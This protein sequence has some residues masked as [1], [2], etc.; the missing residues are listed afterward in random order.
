MSV[1]CTFFK[2]RFIFDTEIKTTSETESLFLLRPPFLPEMHV[3]CEDQSAR[4]SQHFSD[5]FPPLSS[6]S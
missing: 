3:H 6:Q 5:I 4:A 2:T 1:F